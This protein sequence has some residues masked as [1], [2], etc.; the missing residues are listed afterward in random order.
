MKRKKSRSTRGV[1]VEIIYIVTTLQKLYVTLHAGRV[2]WN[3]AMYYEN[4]AMA[5]HAPRGACELKL[6]KTTTLLLS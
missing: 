3:A 6:N 2:S 5:C 4:R 1:W